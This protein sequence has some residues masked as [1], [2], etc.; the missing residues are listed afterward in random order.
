MIEIIHQAFMAELRKI[1][2]EGQAT[3]IENQSADVDSAGEISPAVKEVFSMKE[4][5]KV[6]QSRDEKNN[7][8][9]QAHSSPVI[10]DV[11]AAQ[12]L[13]DIGKKEGYQTAAR[14]GLRHAAEVGKKSYDSGYQSAAKKG[15]E[16]AA[17]SYMKGRDSVKQTMER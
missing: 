13:H 5:T 8:S 3:E 15:I 1:A 12:K 6:R 16:I 7:L 14:E 2:A 4:L 11:E 10:T 17:Q 9:N